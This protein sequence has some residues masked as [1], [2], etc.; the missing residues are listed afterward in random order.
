MQCRD[1]GSTNEADAAFCG[2]C[3][4]PV[5]GEDEKASS[6][7]RKAYVYALLILPVLLLAAALGYYK[8]FLPAGVAA[9]VNGEEIKLSELEA[10]LSQIRN[11][12]GAAPDGAASAGLRY[13]VLNRMITERI[14]LQ[15]AKKAGFEASRAEIADAAAGMRRSSGLGEAAFADAV[16]ARYGSARAFEQKLERD[17][18]IRKCIAGRV[19]PP[20]ADPVSARAAV[21]RWIQSISRSASVRIALAEQ[22]SATGCGCCSGGASPSAMQKTAG[23]SGSPSPAGAKAADAGVRYWQEKHGGEAVTARTTDFGCHIQVDILK[24]NKVVRSLRYQDGA[25]SEM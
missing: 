22:W 16:A 3:G 11:A 21:D 14:A 5:A 2:Q 24:E 10:E 17:L 19:V 20:G 8:F 1:C 12:Q 9:Y 6:R 15:E 23:P 25:I 18:L 7:Q 4:K 13:Q